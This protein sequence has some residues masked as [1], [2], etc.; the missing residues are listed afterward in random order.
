[1]QAHEH[2][3]RVKGM[4]N[5]IS[6]AKK[7]AQMCAGSSSHHDAHCSEQID[8]YQKFRK[9][10]GPDF[11]E[12]KAKSVKASHIAV[13]DMEASDLTEYYSDYVDSQP[14]I[15]PIWR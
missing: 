1:M 13:S 10:R 11:T 4:E 7:E 14:I 12:K 2:E 6:T 15:D 3:V 9:K 5:N 8:K